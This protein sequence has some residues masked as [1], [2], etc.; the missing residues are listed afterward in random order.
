MSNDFWR[1]LGFPRLSIILQRNRSPIRSISF[2]NL[3]SRFLAGTTTDDVLNHFSFYRKEDAAA[4][5]AEQ[6][7]SLGHLFAERMG[8]YLV[9]PPWRRVEEVYSYTLGPEQ[10]QIAS[11]A[12]NPVISRHYFTSRDGSN[13]RCVVTLTSGFDE[14]RYKFV[15]LS[16]PEKNKSAL[17]AIALHFTKIHFPILYSR[18]DHTRLLDSILEKDTLGGP[19]S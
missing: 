12:H 16:V 5:E 1:L 8:S 17:A 10:K 9:S 18:M 11:S 2:L 15:T 14:E 13:Q 4:R 6:I 19:E 3:A 7:A